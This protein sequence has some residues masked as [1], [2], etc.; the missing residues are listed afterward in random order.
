MVGIYFSGTGN[1]R[2]CVE[3]IVSGLD[4]PNNVY[5]IEDKQAVSAIVES[6]TVVFGY[7]V[8]FSN[9][10]KIVR[11]FIDNNSTVF[12][13]KKI[14]IVATMGLFSGDGAG[15]SARLLKKHGAIILGAIH[16]KMPDCIGDSKLLRK[17][18][19]EI[20][21]TIALADK[22]I[23]KAIGDIRNKIYPQEGLN[24]FSHLA[25]LLGQRLYFPNKTKSYYNGI[26]VNKAKCSKCGLCTQ[27]CPMTNITLSK[28]G[29]EFKGECTICYRCF[30]NCP[31]KA[32]TVLFDEIIEQYNFNDYVK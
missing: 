23:D 32:I 13:G 19:E 6:D 1:T 26:K 21:K 24:F 29:I 22:K 28:N 30:S 7:P 17:S 8:Y 10:P 11:N 3:K 16:V 9:L 5:P 18:K 14:F 25:G 12:K 15:C 4:Y 2:H 31:N 27:I 20:N